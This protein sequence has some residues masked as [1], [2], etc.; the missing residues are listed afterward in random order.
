[1]PPE[2]YKDKRHSVCLLKSEWTIPLL[3]SETIVL[4]DVTDSAKSGSNSHLCKTG[5]SKT[6]LP[7][8][9]GFKLSFNL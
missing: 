2:F 6:G 1:M 4:A 8:G 7:C 9:Y 3:F 5:G